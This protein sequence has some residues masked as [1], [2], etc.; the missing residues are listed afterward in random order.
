MLSLPRRRHHLNRSARSRTTI[1]AFFGT[2]SSLAGAV[3]LAATITSVMMRFVSAQQ[4]QQDPSKINGGSCLAMAG[5]NCLAL[6]VDKRFGSGPVMVNIRQQQNQQPGTGAA[7]TMHSNVFSPSAVDDSCVL[8]ALQGLEGDV[9][10]LKQELRDYVETKYDQG[11]L[12]SSSSSSLVLVSNDDVGDDGGD[13]DGIVDSAATSTSISPRAMASLTSHVLYNRKRSP[14]FVEPIVIGLEEEERTMSQEEDDQQDNN[15][16]NNNHNNRRSLLRPFLCSM[17]MIG[18]R[19]TSTSF[20]CAGVASD[21]CYGTAE[22]M[23]RPNLSAAQLIEVCGKAFLS[24]L[25][26]DCLSGYGA[27]LYL[28]TED[29]ITEYELAA[30]ND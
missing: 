22:A 6:A 19:S 20:I 3:L 17:D 28:I 16:N 25:E 14:Y 8:V 9:L 27:L 24:A 7:D 29:G 2:T 5:R 11:S 21:S 15:H 26:R 10:T 1:G 18:A 30:R 13:P 12:L 23:W 4:E